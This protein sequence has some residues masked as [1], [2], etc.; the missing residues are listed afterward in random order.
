MQPVFIFSNNQKQLKDFCK[1]AFLHDIKAENEFFSHKTLDIH[2][3]TIPV[4]ILSKKAII[5]F[6]DVTENFCEMQIEKGA[7][8]LVESGNKTAMQILAD[9]KNTAI[10]CGGP[11]D[12]VSFS[13]IHEKKISV[14][15]QRNIKSVS[16]KRIEPSECIYNTNGDESIGTV[17]LAA[18]LNM[19]LG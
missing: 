16:G 4:D 19:V 10:V 1:T 5:V 18:A 3:S 9:N 14:C 12:T 13:S 8:C 6:L 15:L 11:Q 17:L 2:T 7:V